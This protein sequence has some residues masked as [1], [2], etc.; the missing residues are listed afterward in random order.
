MRRILFGSPIV[1]SVSLNYVKTIL[2]ISR[3]QIPDCEISFAFIGGTV[4]NFARNVL[5]D[6]V[7]KHNMDELVSMDKDLVP[8]MADVVRLL[9]HD[10]PVVTGL[11][12]RKHLLTEYHV[13]GIPGEGPRP[14][15]LQRVENASIGFSKI[16]TSVFRELAQK[17]PERRHRFQGTGEASSF[18]HEFYPMGIVGK[19]TAEGKL[20]RINEFIE[21]PGVSAGG[22]CDYSTLRQI[23]DDT[24][25]SDNSIL[26]EDFYFCRLLREHGIPMY[27][28]TA[29]RIDHSATVELPVPTETLRAML[30]EPWRKDLK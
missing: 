19:N 11:Y 22:D 6:H 16:K 15:L 13:Q 14:D 20:E 10:E 8:T 3:L 12:P 21:G 26:G 4:V 24:D 7:I 25:Y 27:V 30:A 1:G 9:S 28:D 23:L 2:D 18:K 17:T 5:A 29:L